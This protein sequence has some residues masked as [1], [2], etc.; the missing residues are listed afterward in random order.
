MTK[1][2]PVI[3]FLA[4]AALGACTGGKDRQHA[5]ACSAAGGKW[6]AEAAEC[7]IDNRQWCEAR[8]GKFNECASACRNTGRQPCMMICVPVCTMAGSK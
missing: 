6:I 7:E 8:G 3:I 2:A 4:A 1:I 5:A